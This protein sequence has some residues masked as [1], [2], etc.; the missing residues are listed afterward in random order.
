MDP[1]QRLKERFCE[2]TVVLQGR[3]KDR[4]FCQL[5]IAIANYLSSS[6]LHL[7]ERELVG[8]GS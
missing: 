6:V 5:M 7:L 2:C 4:A 8:M 1:L 3:K